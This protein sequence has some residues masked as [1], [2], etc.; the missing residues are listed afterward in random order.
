MEHYKQLRKIVNSKKFET[1]TAL[2]QRIMKK[3]LFF[4]KHRIENWCSA[5][6]KAQYKNIVKTPQRCNEKAQLQKHISE[7][8]DYYMFIA[9]QTNNQ[10]IK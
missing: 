6:K 3:E 2:E 9:K 5:H 4:S 10:N 1:M 8:N 7:Y